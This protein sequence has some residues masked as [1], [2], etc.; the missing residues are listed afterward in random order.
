MGS[1]E[2]LGLAAI[3]PSP[4]DAET[5]ESDTVN[6]DGPPEKAGDAPKK[7]IRDNKPTDMHPDL[8]NAVM[9][10]LGFTED[11]LMA[12]LSHLVNHKTQGSSF[13]GMIEPHHVL[14]LR[15]YVNGYSNNSY[16]GYVT[17]E[18]AQQEYLTFEEEF[19]QDHAIDEAV[20]IAQPLLEEVHAL[21]GA[22]PMVRP[23]RVKDYIIIPHRGDRED[24]V[25]P[26]GV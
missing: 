9:D 23:S 2:P 3:I 19:L 21:Q 26:S 16:R 10:K 1:I 24:L 4:E 25:F 8:Y 13:F 17:L 22:P 6:L 7:S 20:P 12:A 18:D 5:Q 14:W 11:D 15:N